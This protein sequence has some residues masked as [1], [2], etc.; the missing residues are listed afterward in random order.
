MKLEMLMAA[1]ETPRIALLIPCH[2]EA[3]TIGGMVEEIR[4]ILPKA[5]IVVCDNNSTDNTASLAAKA[6]ATV[7]Q[8]PRQGKGYA[9]QRL[10]GAVD[11]DVYAMVDG[12]A[13]YD[14]TALPTLINKL[15]EE[16]L[17]MVVGARIAQ[18]QDAYRAG[19]RWG[20]K[21]ITG[22][23]GL[24]FEARFEDILSGYRVFN[25]AFVKSFPVNT[26]GFTIES[27][28]TI[29]ALQLRIPC[30]EVPTKY[31]ARPS[32]SHSK[33]STWKDGFRISLYI[34]QLFSTERPLAFYGICGGVLALIGVATFFPI[35]NTYLA[36][37]LVPRMPTLMVVG[38]LGV[39]ALICWV[40]GLVLQAITNTR[41]EAKQLAYLGR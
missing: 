35:L 15:T 17:G 18:H 27:A 33:L 22:M 9:V 16:R 21:M 37:G 10:F 29:H 19:H 3:T 6:G 26:G 1:P 31:Y 4:K 20:N 11:A 34:A 28:M 2:N 13:T 12:D 40:A 25:R 8:E 32:G 14:L 5:L 7:L 24:L 38:S 39:G 41:R 23:L 30:G 36:T